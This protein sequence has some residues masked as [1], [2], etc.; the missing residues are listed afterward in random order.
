MCKQWCQGHQTTGNAHVVLSDESS[1]TLFSVSGR[2]YILKTPKEASNPECLVPT[3][4]HGGGYVT[5]WAEIL[6]YY[7][8]LNINFHGQIIAKE[9]VD[10][11]GNQVHPVTQTLFPNNDAVFQ[12]DNAHIHT[13]GT[14]QSLFDEHEYELQHLPWPAQSPDLRIV[15]HSGQLRRL[16]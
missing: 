15:E 16:E 5:F 3:V 14:V 10:R 6:W 13:A 8:G 2:V 12:D 7:V 1:F 4:K 11:L 9:Y